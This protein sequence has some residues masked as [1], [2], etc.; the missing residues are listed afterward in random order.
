MAKGIDILEQAKAE[1]LNYGKSPTCDLMLQLEQVIEAYA[2]GL[3]DH[4]AKCGVVDETSPETPHSGNK[5]HRQI[6][7]FG[8]DR[9]TVDV[10]RVLTAFQVGEPGL[11]HAIKKLLC[12]GLRGKGTAKQDLSEAVDAVLATIKSTEERTR[13]RYYRSG[14]A[15]YARLVSRLERRR[16]TS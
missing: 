10:Y 15:I 12:A 13:S 8:G 9:V 16:K 3:T 14:S 4:P 6:V 1:L 2:I 5:Y 11:Q 7:G